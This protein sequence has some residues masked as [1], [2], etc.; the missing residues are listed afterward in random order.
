[1]SNRSWKGTILGSI[2]LLLSVFYTV[3]FFQKAE[4]GDTMIFNIAHLQSLTN[5]FTSPINFNY[6]NHSGSQINLFSPWLTI[7]SGTIFVNSNVTYG[8]SIYLTLITFLTF[9]SAYVYM[10]RFSHDTLESLLFSLIY[11]LSLNR[12][13]QVFQVQRLENYLVLIF[14]PMVY[15][16]IYQV[17]KNQRWCNLAWGMSLIIWTSP[18]MAVGVLLT[19]VPW[20]ILMIFKSISHH[21]SYWG[22]LSLSLL[23]TFGLV[24]LTTIG[25][26]VPLGTKLLQGKLQQNPR[27]NFNYVKWF[28]QLHLSQI[29][30]ILLIGIAVL[31]VLVL[32]VIFMNSQFSYKLIM[33]EMIPLTISLFVK[34][35]SLVVDWSRLVPAFQSILDL[36][37]AIIVSRIVILIFQEGPGILKLLLMVAT[38]GGMSFLIYNQADQ[39]HAEQRITSASKINYQKYVINYHDRAVEGQNQFLVNNKKAS[40][41]Y[42]TKANDYWIQYYDP[43]SATMDIPVQKYSGYKIQ[44]NNEN[45]RTMKSNRGTIELQTNP[46]KS[47]VEIHT[48][49]DWIGIISLLANLFSFIL[50]GYLSLT[51]VVGKNKKISNKS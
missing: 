46:G 51:K 22:R 36:F 48:Q 3:M 9:V 28:D 33:L 30:Q 13:V 34:T 25:F 49:Y 43:Q 37:L 17:L 39:I 1:M 16:G 8:F 38:I 24:V 41:S 50:L 2:F 15:Y 18:Y 27:N 31:S 12:F 32:I 45:V 40:V 21:W 29:Q 44:L 6:W 47:I 10:N 35:D 26:L 19:L 23:K 7:L 4:F 11:T 42:Y 14:L 20:I 5:I